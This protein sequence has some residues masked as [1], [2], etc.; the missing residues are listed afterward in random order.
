MSFTCVNTKCKIAF[1]LGQQYFL[2]VVKRIC[3]NEVLSQ[4]Q[5]YVFVASFESSKFVLLPIDYWMKK[6]I[7][8]DSHWWHKST[9]EFHEVLTLTITWHSLHQGIELM[10]APAFGIVICRRII[11]CNFTFLYF[12]MKEVS[13]CEGSIYDDSSPAYKNV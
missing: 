12:I 6:Q 11:I 13:I 9:S 4:Y 5:Q 2:F 7:F 8:V 3:N 1:S 10:N